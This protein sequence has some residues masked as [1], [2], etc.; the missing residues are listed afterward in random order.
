MTNYRKTLYTNYFTNQAGREYVSHQKQKFEQETT[1]FSNEIVSQLPSDK[2]IKILDIGCGI[3]SLLA[4]CKQAGYQNV[5]GID[6]SEEMIKIANK[7]G[8]T[9]ARLGDLNEFL[10]DKIAVYDVVTGM[11]IIEHFTKDELLTLIE[12]IK[13]VLKPSGKVIFRTPNLDAPFGNLYANG[14]F[15]HENYLNKNSAMQVMMAMGFK[16]VEVLS[17]YLFVDG[18]LKELIRKLVWK[19]FLLKY[20]IELFASARTYKNTVFTPNMIIIA[21]L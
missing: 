10:K 12:T 14:D 18:F 6:L 7:F 1:H 11:D 20:K 19:M 9:E 15:T 17:S 4:A 8:V 5:E 2:T 13:K 3:G 16:D 21:K